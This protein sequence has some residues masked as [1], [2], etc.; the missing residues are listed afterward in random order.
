MIISD[1]AAKIDRASIGFVS[2][3]F[4]DP[5]SWNSFCISQAEID[6]VANTI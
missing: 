5:T 1:L 6:A 4:D 2:F 3:G